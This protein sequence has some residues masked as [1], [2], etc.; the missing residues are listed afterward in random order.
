[1]EYDLKVIK[2]TRDSSPLSSGSVALEKVS[3]HVG[4]IVRQC[5]QRPTW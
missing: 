1:M 4:K 2:G 5:V 3:C